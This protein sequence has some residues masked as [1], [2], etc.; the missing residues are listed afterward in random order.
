MTRQFDAREAERQ[1][2]QEALD[3]ARPAP[4]RNRL[5]QFATPTRLALEMAQL[6]RQHLPAR[7]DVRFLDP[8]VGSGAFFYAVRKVL[9]ARVRAAVGFEIDPGVAA[10]AA[11][12]WAAF[13][14]SVRL[15]DFCAAAPTT[16]ADKAT[17]ILCNPPYVRHHHLAAAQKASLR[18]AVEGE[19]FRVS[20]LAGLYCYVLLLAHKWLAKG[21]TGVWIM[22]AEF[23]D[24]NYGRAIK[25]Y[26]TSRVTLHQLHRFDPEDVQFAD[27]LVSSVVA[28]FVNTPPARGHRVRLTSGGRLLEPQAVH[29]IPVAELAPAEKWGPRFTGLAARPVGAGSLTVGDLFAVKRGLATGANEFFILRRQQARALGLPDAVLRPI[30]PSPRH[31]PGDCIERAPEGFP[32]GLPE[33]VLLDCDLPIEAVRKRHAGLARYLERGEREGIPRR[34]LP[35][36]RPLWYRQEQRPPAPILCTYMGRQNGGRALRFLRNRSDATAPNVYLMLYP[37]PRLA[38]EARRQPEVLDRLFEALAELARDLA[39]GGRVYGG[40]LNKIEPKELEAVELPAWARE[41]FSHF[42]ERLVMRDLFEKEGAALALYT[43]LPRR[44]ARP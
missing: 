30:L 15:E 22:P 24:V 29:E 20:G 8:G 44:R 6:A 35:A 23:L 13:G 9:G 36:H 25:D 33:L 40:G 12:L 7:G 16:D 38:A 41:R 31:I 18:R 37:R 11:Q 10:E 3:R 34:Y 5:G 28:V 19:G 1:A 2:A 42:V 17:L 14:L 27:A 43:N 4:Q 21:G 26:L 39:P 32:V